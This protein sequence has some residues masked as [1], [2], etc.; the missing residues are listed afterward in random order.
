MKRFLLA[1]IISSLAMISVNA[2]T[3]RSFNSQSDNKL[4]FRVDSVD[5]RSD[6]TRIYGKLIGRPHT[7]NRIDGVTALT[8]GSALTSTDI[9]GVDFHRYFQWEDDG[10]IP[11]ELDFP[12]MSIEGFQLLFDTPLG[13]SQTTV[14][15]R[16]K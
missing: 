7:S 16:K 12:I 10:I 13:Q 4:T 1:T 11:I 3:V 15:V 8:S 6:L 2:K 14:K 9:D 5:Y